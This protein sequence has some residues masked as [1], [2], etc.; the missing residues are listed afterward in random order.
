M[1]YTYRGD[2]HTAEHLK[3]Q[4]CEAVRNAAGKCIRGRNANMLVRFANGDQH[5]VL[6]RQLR[7]LTT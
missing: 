7:K 4:P 2:K 6:A 5:V 1:D 3:G